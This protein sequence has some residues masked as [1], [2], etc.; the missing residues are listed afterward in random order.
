MGREHVV[1]HDSATGLEG[2]I[3]VEPAA[4]DRV[5]F[6]AIGVCCDCLDIVGIIGLLIHAYHELN[7]CGARRNTEWL[8]I[9]CPGC[10]RAESAGRGDCSSL[11]CTARQADNRKL[12]LCFA[13]GTGE[14]KPA[15]CVRADQ[16]DVVHFGQRKIEDRDV[17]LIVRLSVELGISSAGEQAVELAGVIAP[18]SCW[19]NLGA[20]EASLMPVTPNLDS[21]GR[22]R[23]V[24]ADR[25]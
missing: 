11:A 19:I 22:P 10:R 23:Q 12:R 5:Y 7:R 9:H 13:P 16:A 24:H 4:E 15:R 1:G 8:H 2:L 25:R 20:S 3:D 17:I 21:P 14:R 6:G 18:I